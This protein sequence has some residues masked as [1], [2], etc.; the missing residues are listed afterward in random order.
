MLDEGVECVYW[1]PETNINTRLTGIKPK[2]L[3]TKSLSLGGLKTLFPQAA[4][5]SVLS[6]K[7]KKSGL[8]GQLEI[9]ETTPNA[10]SLVWYG[11]IVKR[12]ET[13]KERE[14]FR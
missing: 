3:K 12:K 8:C 4:A 11:Q 2:T 7:I 13:T 10:K 14:K 5:I 1:P 6:L 9:S